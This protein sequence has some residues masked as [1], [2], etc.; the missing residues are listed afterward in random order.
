MERQDLPERGPQL[1]EADIE[2]RL[3]ER[4]ELLEQFAQGDVRALAELF[5]VGTGARVA[6]HEIRTPAV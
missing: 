3:R 4:P 1:T 6:A 2:A 5:E